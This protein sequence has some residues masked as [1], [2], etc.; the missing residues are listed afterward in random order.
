[1]FK[2]NYE[3]GLNDNG[4]PCIELPKDYK[5]RPEDRFFAIE[6]TRY[7]LQDLLNR[8]GGDLEPSDT[9]QL[10]EAERLLGQVGDEISELL[11]KKIRLGDKI[12]LIEYFKT[13]NMLIV[14]EPHEL[15]WMGQ[16]IDI[17]TREYVHWTHPPVDTY[18]E[19]IDQALEYAIEKTWHD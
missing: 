7:I 11:F 13:K 15:G 18:D 17:N 3:I 1:M 6:I 2:I 12:K 8:L 4:R 19:G 5:Q 14:A 16:I 9:K 10:D